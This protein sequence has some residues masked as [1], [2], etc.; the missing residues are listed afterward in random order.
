MPK[1][2]RH[3]TRYHVRPV[4]GASFVR[5]KVVDTDKRGKTVARTTEKSGAESIARQLNEKGFV[6]H[7]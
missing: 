5:W 1:A 3:P 2:D 6:E 4:V 7:V